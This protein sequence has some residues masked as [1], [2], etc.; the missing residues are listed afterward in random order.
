MIGITPKYRA[1]FSGIPMSEAHGKSGIIKT[2]HVGPAPEKC[3]KGSL[4]LRSG[5]W[6]SALT[7]PHSSGLILQSRDEEKY[8]CCHRNIIPWL[9]S[10]N[11]FL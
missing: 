4:G 1:C 8:G 7:E 3:T 10:V 11:P 9:P 5:G 2:A 6:D